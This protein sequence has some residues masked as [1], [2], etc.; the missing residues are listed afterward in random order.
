[1]VFIQIYAKNHIDLNIQKTEDIEW[2]K[3][4]FKWDE[5]KEG[6]WEIEHVT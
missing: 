4:M 1:M 3:W 2:N 6:V 5:A